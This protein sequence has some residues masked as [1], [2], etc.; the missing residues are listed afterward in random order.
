METP[1]V[2]DLR[3][4][5]LRWYDQNKRNLPWRDCGDSYKVW[6]SEI[7]LQQTRVDQATPFF[8]RFINEFPTVF[9]LAESSQD[10]LL[11]TWEGLGYYSRARNLHAA[12]K[13]I[14][15]RFNGNLPES[16]TELL[17]L[18]GIGPYTA[19]AIS[20]ICFNEYRAV[21]DGNVIRVLSRLYGIEDDTRSSRTLNEI[22]TFASELLDTERPGDFNQAVMELGATVCSPK[23]PSCMQCPWKHDCIAHSMVKT[24]SIPYKSPAKKKPHHRIVIG[25]IENESK[26]ILISKRPDEKMLGGLWEFP[27]GKAEKNEFDEDALKRELMEEVG[28]EVE[29]LGR[30]PEIKHAYSHFSITMVPF[31]VRHISGEPKNLESSQIRW[32]KE[33]ELRTYPFPRANTKLMD[34]L[35]KSFSP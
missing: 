16:Y 15:A 10:R 25:I 17:E 29:I 6:I 28:I 2:F 19:A 1:E 22:Q 27:G 4:A 35:E 23:H 33:S 13:E 7:M 24:E 11:K 8:L 32:I 18:K 30:L 5:L 21:V 9:D 12:A 31:R 20:S 26:E 3:K 34:I 14:V